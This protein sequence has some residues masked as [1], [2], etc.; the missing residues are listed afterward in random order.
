MWAAIRPRPASQP[1]VHQGPALLLCLPPPLLL[2]VLLL[3]LLLLL[4]LLLVL[5]LLLLLLLLRMGMG[6]T[7]MG[8]VHPNQ[9]T[10]GA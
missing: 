4:L 3:R 9:G 6:A 2:L 5:L 7:G 1:L 10:R 8:A